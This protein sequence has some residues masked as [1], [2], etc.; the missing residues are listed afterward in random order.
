MNQI[1]E[2]LRKVGNIKGDDGVHT[3]IVYRNAEHNEFVVKYFANGV[4]LGPDTASYEATMQ[5]AVATARAELRYLG[6][7]TNR[8]IGQIESSH[9]QVSKLASQFK[10]GRPMKGLSKYNKHDSAGD[11]TVLQQKLKALESKFDQSYAKSSDHRH[12]IEQDAIAGQIVKLKEEIKQQEHSLNFETMSESIDLWL[13]MRIV[14]GLVSVK[15]IVEGKDVYGGAINN[16]RLALQKSLIDIME[17]GI[18]YDDATLS[19][20]EFFKQELAEVGPIMPTTG[21]NR[22][23]QPP[24]PAPGAQT[25]QAVA[26]ASPAANVSIQS[27]QTGTQQQPMTAQDLEMLKKDIGTKLNDPNVSKDFAELLAKVM[28]RK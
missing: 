16:D 8:P 18:E 23:P 4:D 7:K 5:D 28:Q 17:S 14:D 6:S 22:L 9:E 1:N 20:V 25:Q 13:K 21:M 24:K 11:I 15:D 10:S 26:P 3:A 2:G 27:N 19:L 12:W